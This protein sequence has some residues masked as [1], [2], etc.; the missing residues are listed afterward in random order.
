MQLKFLQSKKF[1][2]GLILLVLVMGGLYFNINQILSEMKKPIVD[3]L[4]STL[5]TD[6]Q[7][8]TLQLSGFAKISAYDIV[9]KDN[10]G[11]NLIQAE[12]LVVNCSILELLTNYSQPLKVIKDIELNSPQINLIQRDNWNYNF[13]LASAPQQQKK[14]NE[15][16]PI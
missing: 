11:S 9:V 10:N 6:I 8:E 4:E 7:L 12:E 2:I 3:K 14:K 1:I 16:F 15:L 13:L 5:G